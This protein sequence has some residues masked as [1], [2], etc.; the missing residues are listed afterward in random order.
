MSTLTL[1]LL[2]GIKRF[3]SNSYKGHSQSSRA[4]CCRVSRR[5]AGSEFLTGRIGSL[6]PFPETAKWAS[7][8]PTYRSAISL[9]KR[10]GTKRV[11]AHSAIPRSAAP[12]RE[13]HRHPPCAMAHAASPA[14]LLY[15][16]RLPQCSASPR[17]PSPLPLPKLSLVLENHLAGVPSASVLGEQRGSSGKQQRCSVNC[18][19]RL[20]R[21]KRSRWATASTIRARRRCSSTWSPASRRRTPPGGCEQGGTPLCPLSTIEVRSSKKIQR[22]SFLG[23][24]C[25]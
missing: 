1:W 20:C 9:A 12:N 14:S 3:R 24:L 16:P 10:S 18:S 17:S 19:T 7:S 8:G 22:A 4:T 13:I 21:E 23:S 25:S 11:Q 5:R 2:L 15:M 6:G